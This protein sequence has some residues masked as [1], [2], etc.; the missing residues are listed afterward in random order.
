MK[1]LTA[2]TCALAGLAL[3]TSLGVAAH[4]PEYGQEKPGSCRNMP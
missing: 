2:L 4:D 1:P 3:L